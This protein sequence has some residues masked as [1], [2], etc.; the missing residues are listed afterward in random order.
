MQKSAAAGQLPS[1]AGLDDGR[2]ISLAL[3]PILQSL[4]VFQLTGDPKEVSDD[5][6]IELP[7]LLIQSQLAGGRVSIAPD[8][9]ERALPPDCRRFFCANDIDVP[10]ALPLQEVLKQL[11]ADSLR[12]RDDQEER[13][14]EE[15]FETPFST[16][17]AE[18]AKRFNK[19][20]VPIAK[21]EPAAVAETP[22]T[23][24]APVP[25]APALDA[26]GVIAQASQLPGVRACALSFADGLNLAGHLPTEIGTDGLCAV[27]PSFLQRLVTHVLD[28]KVGKLDAMTLHC[29]KSTITFLMH[30]NVSMAALHANGD[31]S[32]EVRNQLSEML[33]KLSHTYSQPEISHVHH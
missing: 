13:R 12:M 28:T 5:A 2:K 16:P 33:E 31:L 8:V 21:P 10:V 24:P 20:P 3:K 29:A 18:D 6:R 1:D 7:F 26:K 4:P 9:F 14:Q 11:P 19:A 15:T 30:G 23:S 32:A 27:A 22:A 25:A 17:A